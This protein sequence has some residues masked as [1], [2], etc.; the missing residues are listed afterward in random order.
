MKRFNSELKFDITRY[1]IKLS[2]REH[3]EILPNNFQNSKTRLAQLWNFLKLWDLLT[4]YDKIIKAY[5]K[6]NIIE[7]IET[8]GKLGLVH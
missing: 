7:K 6:E 1:C 8:F 2:F 4:N 5:E 3:H